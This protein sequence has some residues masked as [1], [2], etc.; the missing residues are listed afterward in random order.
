[1]FW[2]GEKEQS[3]RNK[4]KKKKP[5]RS[6]RRSQRCFSAA[7]RPD[8]SPA[9]REAIS[10]VLCQ[11]VS[12][13]LGNH[14]VDDLTRRLY[15]TPQFYKCASSFEHN[16]KQSGPL[17]HDLASCGCAWRLS[18]CVFLHPHYVQFIQ[19]VSKCSSSTDYCCLCLSVLFLSL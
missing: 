14:P 5:E 4:P 18:V 9:Y 16:N 17:E 13:E 19:P 8:T 10:P 15:H 7:F 2:A 3:C 6:S 1:M 12:A 11:C